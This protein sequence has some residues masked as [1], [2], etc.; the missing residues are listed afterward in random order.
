MD[1]RHSRHPAPAVKPKSAGSMPLSLPSDKAAYQRPRTTFPSSNIE[2]N[3]DNDDNNMDVSRDQGQ[4]QALAK[5]CRRV[6]LHAVG[7]LN[8]QQHSSGHSRRIQHVYRHRRRR[9]NSSSGSH[10]DPP[11]PSISANIVP[12]NHVIF[13]N[14]PDF[15]VDRPLGY[16]HIVNTMR[17]NEKIVTGSFRLCDALATF[18]FKYNPRICRAFFSQ[19]GLPVQFSLT[20][21]RRHEPPFKTW[22]FCRTEEGLITVE[23][24]PKGGK[25]FCME[26][27]AE[28][29]WNS[30]VV[31]ILAKDM[32]MEKPLTESEDKLTTARMDQIGSEIGKLI[33][34]GCLHTRVP[35]L[36]PTIH[37]NGQLA[38][39]DWP[40]EDRGHSARM[41]E[42]GVPPPAPP[43]GYRMRRFGPALG[44]SRLRY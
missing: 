44:E 20:D 5:I 40:R 15:P 41:L 19:D 31:P 17:F 10:H 36:E 18:F 11:L 26:Y 38:H 39:A 27:H 33:L 32:N 1:H 29:L 30:Q 37:I 35:Y 28:I 23:C 24:Y 7:P 16:P 8:W 12:P 22:T 21:R 42:I 3:N 9:D 25:H 13:I 43:G 6:A 2:N 4:H 34:L 14:W